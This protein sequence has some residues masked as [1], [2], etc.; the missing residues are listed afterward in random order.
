M[1]NPKKKRGFRTISVNENIYFWKFNGVIDVRPKGKK[2]NQLIIDFGY[3]D[4]F[5][6]INDLE[7]KPPP[8]EPKVVTPKF[9]SQSIEMAIQIG[10]NPEL[11]KGNTRIEYRDKKYTQLKF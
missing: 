1:S 7:N 6:Y 4:E 10:W 3:Y 2:G 9:I 8:F 5:L 11:E